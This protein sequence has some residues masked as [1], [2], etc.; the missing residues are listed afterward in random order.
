MEIS[1]FEILLLF[2]L[3]IILSLFIAFNV[4]NI[5]DKNLNDIQI[6]V[7]ACPTPVC[8]TIKC[9]YGVMDVEESNKKETQQ[10]NKIEGFDVQT[11]QRNQSSGFGYENANL[12][13]QQQMNVN[14]LTNPTDI[15]KDST[16]VITNTVVLSQGYHSSDKVNKGNT[17]TYPSDDDIVRY[18][19]CYKDIRPRN[20]SFKETQKVCRPY[21][22]DTVRENSSN[23]VNAPFMSPFTNRV[24]DIKSRDMKFFVPT[25]YMGRDP[26][27][28][29]ISYAKMSIGGPADVDQIG[30]IPV[31]DF[32]GEP[33]PLNGLV[34]NK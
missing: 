34:E 22:G 16:P 12:Y 19:G 14:S 23:V 18:D 10:Q 6:N 2:S 31:N 32:D 26:N 11:L 7:P 3:A 28:S 27:I 21:T 29:G 8:P 33:V 24:G 5:V 4:I 17:I 25:V 13:S 1:A 30:S 9:K 20:V 15:R